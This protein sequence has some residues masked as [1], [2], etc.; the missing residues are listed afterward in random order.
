MAASQRIVW[1]LFASFIAT[2]TGWLLI[3]FAYLILFSPPSADVRWWRN[4]TALYA[5]T[6]YCIIGVPIALASERIAANISRSRA[7][8][9]GGLL[10][11]AIAAIPPSLFLYPLTGPA[12]FLAG[13]ISTAVYVQLIAS[14]TPAE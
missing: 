14:Q 1:R 2:M 3:C 10:G 6:A 8:I 13:L 7:V 4:L 5:I 12:G 11:A 9:Y